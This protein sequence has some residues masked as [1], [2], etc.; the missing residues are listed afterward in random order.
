MTLLK[1][2]IEA[3]KSKEFVIS[4]IV[5]LLL[6]LNFN[7]WTI[8]SD[9]HA[10][11]AILESIVLDRNLDL[12]NQYWQHE[13]GVYMLSAPKDNP[14]RF[15]SLYGFGAPALNIPLYTIAIA[16]E[17]SLDL[18]ITY[19]GYSLIRTAAVNA[20]G[21]LLA[22][23]SMLFCFTAI[24]KIGLKLSATGMLAL[25][26]STPLFFYSSIVPSFS[27]AADAFI[28]SAIVL[29]FVWLEK[30][31]QKK[32][33][34]FAALGLLLGFAISVRYYNAFLFLPLLTFF[35]LKKKL[36]EA[37]AFSLGFLVFAIIIPLYWLAIM[38]SHGIEIAATESTRVTQNILPVFLLDLLFNPVHGLFLWSPITIASIIGLWFLFKQK[39][40]REIALLLA[41]LF[42]VLVLAYG[43]TEIWSAGW[44]FSA[45]YLTGLFPVFAI[46]FA[47]FET[48]YG[49]AA[50]IAAIVFLL[51]SGFLM[52]N[53]VFG[54]I[55]GETGTPINV[56]QNWLSGK[57][58]IELFLRELYKF[59]LADNIM[60]IIKP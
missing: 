9:G 40:N 26:I 35:V 5:F 36:K 8:W 58:T 24:K 1:E 60:K 27:H 31:K 18:N 12:T 20:T 50:K 46:G 6:A 21:N 3:A 28:L 51:Y 4:A 25:T 54:F 17:K 2:I 29:L 41:A 32:L 47:A 37:S 22:L 30:E 10:Y 45:R 56:I 13:G 49:K 59:T 55:H 48:K 38:G 53:E 11:Y 16:I 7:S 57:T 14:Q 15:A 34:G 52:L 23:F 43:R 33:A 39:T 42:T 44:S 19:Y